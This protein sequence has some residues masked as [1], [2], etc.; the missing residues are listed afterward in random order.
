M[1]FLIYVWAKKKKTGQNVF[2]LNSRLT[3]E[4][5]KKKV[6]ANFH[7][8]CFVHLRHE[9]RGENYFYYCYVN[10]DS[11]Q[12][13]QPHIIFWTWILATTGIMEILER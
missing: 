8:A 13:A 12:K 1:G 3:D 4:K 9:K 5:E 11:L 7:I 6:W 2:F 10:M